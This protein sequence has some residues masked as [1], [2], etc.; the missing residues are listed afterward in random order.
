MW[1]RS[2]SFQLLTAAVKTS[3]EMISLRKAYDCDAFQDSASKLISDTSEWML[4]DDL[5]QPKQAQSCL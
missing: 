1:L 4:P 3:W 2:R 5:H